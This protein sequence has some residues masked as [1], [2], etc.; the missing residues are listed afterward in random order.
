MFDKAART[1]MNTR[2]RTS[3]ARNWPS[4]ASVQAAGHEMKKN[5]PAVLAKTMAKKGKAAAE[6]QRKAIMLSKARLS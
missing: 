6:A 2:P 4:E 1:R 5:P 3:K